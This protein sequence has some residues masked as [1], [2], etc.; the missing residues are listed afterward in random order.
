MIADPS[1]ACGDCRASDA[2]AVR[3]MLELR[4]S[5]TAVLG[6]ACLWVQL[7]G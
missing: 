7:E 3:V 4:S 2:P 6:K 1:A 5:S